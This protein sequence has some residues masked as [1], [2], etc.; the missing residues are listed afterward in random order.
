M[1]AINTYRKHCTYTK[2]TIIIEAS[3]H[4]WNYKIKHLYISFT[5]EEKQ[6]LP[7]SGQPQ[8]G[9]LCK[10]YKVDTTG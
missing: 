9:Q 6:K 3:E 10:N 8:S 4:N 5:E 1:L 7:R 2:A